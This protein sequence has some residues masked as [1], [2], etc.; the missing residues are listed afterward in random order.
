MVRGS[1]ICAAVA[2]C[3]AGPCELRGSEELSQR[4][5]RIFESSDFAEKSF[6]PA[7]WIRGGNAFVA[8]EDSVAS[9]GSKDMVEHDTATG[10]RTIL[11]SAAQITPP[12]EKPLAISDYSW[13]EDFSHLL[14]FTAAQKVWRVRTRGDYWVLDRKSGRLRKLGG[15]APASSLMFAKFSPDGSQVAYVRGNN[16]YVEDLATGAIRALTSDGSATLINGTSDWVYEEELNLRDGFRWSPDSKS[17]AFWQFDS[18][19][20]EQFSIINNTDS[21]YPKIINIPYPKAG[22]KNSSVRVGVVSASGGTPV[23]INIP[24]DSRENYLFRMNWTRDGRLVIGQ[25]NRRQDNAIIFTADPQTGAA[26][27]IFRDHDDAWVDIP[28][29]QGVREATEAFEWLNGGKNFVWLSERDGWRHAYSVSREGGAPA[30]IT[31]GPQDVMELAAVDPAS[32]WLYF[33]AAGNDATQRY[34]YRAPVDHDGPPVRLSPGDQAGTHSYDISPDCRWAFHTWS[35]FDRPPVTELVSLPEHRVVRTLEENPA[36]RANTASITDPPVEFLRVPLEDGENLDGWLVKPRGFN[37]AKKYPLIVYVYGE[38]AST[39]VVDTWQGKRGLFHRALA[40]QGYLVA[41]FDNRGTPAPKGR[42]W[43]KSI[44]GEVGVL[45]ARDQTN[46]VLS[47]ARQRPYIDLNRVGVWGWSGGGS[48]TLNLMFRSP[49]LYR[50]GVAVAPVPDQKLYDT[51]Y[52]ERYMGLPAEN[53]EGYRLGSPINFAGGLRGKLLI[54]HG[55]GDDNVHFQGTQELINVLIG[56][57]KP[58]DFMEYP[59]RTH[60]ISEGA[61]TS[62]HV[63]SLIA[64]YFQEHLPPGGQEP[65]GN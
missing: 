50:V 37:P 8:I 57:G 23:W 59:N 33:T 48:N 9:P 63:Y 43:R 42:A 36:L 28:E 30:L 13:S 7:R 32:H 6:G 20:V 40:A 24:G 35:G 3:I 12:K 52:Q 46:A 25:L 17:I 31:R 47:L 54:V 45:S 39:T 56:K 44:Y 60:S 2:F 29:S 64:R 61:G 1:L 26:K 11:V 16:L 5:R 41:S 53:A 15:D 58:F 27:E 55:T 51:I 49:D 34:L 65:A 10:K 22:T 18:T 14:V 19:G 38:P 4:L 21:L 62:L